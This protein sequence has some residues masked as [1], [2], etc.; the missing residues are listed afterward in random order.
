MSILVAGATGTTGG[1]VLHALARAGAAPRAMTRS[2]EAAADLRSAGFDAVVADLSE[3][4]SL[5]RAFDGVIAAYLAQPASPELPARERA[6]AQAAR[7]VG[8]HVVKLAALGSSS[9]SPTGFGRMHAES[10]AAIRASGATWTFLHPN[11]FMQNTLQLRAQLCSGVVRVPVPDA[12]WSI[13]DARDL[14]AVAA[15]VLRDPPAH[16]GATYE[17]T[18]PEPSSAREQVRVLSELLDAPLTVEELPIDAIVGALAPWHGERVRELY[19][20]YAAGAAEMVTPTVGEIT[21]TPA[22]DYRAF[23]EDHLQAI[24]P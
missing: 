7:D 18:G 14:A 6:F 16:V 21:G 13:I 8:A 15:I 1:A 12:R 24:R 4:E 20:L 17:L 22:R 11:G 19:A 10:E 2:P 23:A 5:A 9:D 3:P